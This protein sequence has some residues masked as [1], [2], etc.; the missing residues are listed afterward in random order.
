MRVRL[1]FVEELLGTASANP[2]IHSEF[3]ASK[4]PDAQTREEEVAAI[5][6]DGEIQKAMTIFPKENGKPFVWDYQIKGFFKDACSML[7]KVGDTGEK[8]ASGKKIKKQVNEPCKLAAYK[9]IIDGVIFVSP[10]KIFLTLP[11][12][13]TI[14]S[15]ERPLR[16]QIAK[17]VRQERQLNLR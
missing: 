9:K 17:H 14:G 1:T 16:W 3:I 11:K 8:D 10:R 6:V 7:V 13:E 12:N 4:A 2:D 5:G 15:C